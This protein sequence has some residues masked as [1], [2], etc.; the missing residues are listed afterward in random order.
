MQ[1]QL[2]YTMLVSGLLFTLAWLCAGGVMWILFNVVDGMLQESLSDAP[3]ATSDP[4]PLHVVMMLWPLF[5]LLQVAMLC[6]MLA[7]KYERPSVSDMLYA[8][9]RRLVKPREV[10][11]TTRSE[12]KP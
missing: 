12:S 11:F 6:R 9:G 1:G 7:K 3:R 4:P 2:T 8:F 10:H 5:A